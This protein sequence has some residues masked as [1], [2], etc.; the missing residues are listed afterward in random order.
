MKSSILVSGLDNTVRER[1]F[2]FPVNKLQSMIILDFNHENTDLYDYLIRCCRKVS[3]DLP[4]C[5]DFSSK[6]ISDTLF[7]INSDEKEYHAARAALKLLEDVSRALDNTV[8]TRERYFALSEPDG[9]DKAMEALRFRGVDTDIFIARYTRFAEKFNDI[10]L[11][12]D[13]SSAGIP[14]PDTVYYIKPSRADDTVHNKVLIRQINATITGSKAPITL[15]INEGLVNHGEDIL[16]LIINCADAPNINMLYFTTNIFAS[17][18]ARELLSCFT[19]HIFSRHSIEAAQDVSRYFGSHEVR[20]TKISITHD[21]RIHAYT[22]PDRIFHRD[23]TTTR[24]V[25]TRTKPV[26]EAKR[27]AGLPNGVVV[28]SSA[29]S[30]LTIGSI[31][32]IERRLLL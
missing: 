8:L 26:V 25:D 11:I 20:E 6:N 21:N 9:F 17:P 13:I 27:I 31:D 28:I 14:D 3:T 5:T 18:R 32:V 24:S 29:A 22:L 23:S 16:D 2:K 19:N 15:V 30:G 10:D 1:I 4:C 12:M 7:R